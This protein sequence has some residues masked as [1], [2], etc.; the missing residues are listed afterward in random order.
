MLCLSPYRTQGI[1]SV[2][3]EM[4]IHLWEGEN[5]VVVHVS[6]SGISIFYNSS[7]ETCPHFEGTEI[8]WQNDLLE[9]IQSLFT[10]HVVLSSN[11]INILLTYL[12][13]QHELKCRF[14]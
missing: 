10:E 2:N 9:F 3:K 7:Q 5:H 8:R 12:L 4:K 13:K 6:F 11:A 14:K 1:V